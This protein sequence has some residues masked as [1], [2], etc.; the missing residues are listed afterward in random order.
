MRSMIKRR[1][2]RTLMLVSVHCVMDIFGVF[3]VMADHDCL[4]SPL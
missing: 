2:A 4:R 3:E 1:G